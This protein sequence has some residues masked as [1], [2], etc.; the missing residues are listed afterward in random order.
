MRVLQDHQLLEER[1]A[2]QK[3]RWL[4]VQGEEGKTH[5]AGLEQALFGSFRNVLR[6]LRTHPT[7]CQGLSS[8][9]TYN[10]SQKLAEALGGLQGLLREREPVGPA[11]EQVQRD[12]SWYM[13]ELSLRHCNNM[14]VLSTLEED[15]A[16]ATKDKDAETLKKNKV[17]RK[18]K[19]FMLQ[20]EKI[21]EDFA[22]RMLQD[23]DNQNLS[24]RKTSEIR[25]ANMQKDINQLCMQLNN[26]ITENR[27]VEMTLRRRRNKVESEIEN[28]IQK[29]DAD[30][31]EKQVELEEMSVYYAQESEELQ[32]LEEHY[33]VLELEY[34]QIMEE[35]HLAQKQKEEQ[36]RERIIQ[37]QNAVIIQAHWRG[38][39]RLQ[40][41]HRK[42]GEPQTGIGGNRRR[43][44]RSGSGA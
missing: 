7:V 15:V 26:L 29:Y 1:F 28:W 39:Q 20:R 41:S 6:Y 5:L 44:L 24:Y 37:E 4:E 43:G 8:D 19:S 13:D 35:R 11:E 32:E 23:V 17:I 34:S 3:Q 40:G 38:F 14:E 12:R 42:C 21:S 22:I 2:T 16:A 36:E 18:L 31:S 10:G 27:E 30:M 9:A 33:E 25:R